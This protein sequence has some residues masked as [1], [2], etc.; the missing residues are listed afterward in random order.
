MEVHK[1]HQDTKIGGGI[2]LLTSCES[3][4]LSIP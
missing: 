1:L 2:I 3:G 4:E